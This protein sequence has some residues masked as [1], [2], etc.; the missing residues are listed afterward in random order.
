MRVSQPLP[1]KTK[2]MEKSGAA[3]RRRRDGDFVVGTMTFP[4]LSIFVLLPVADRSKAAR[5]RRCRCR[6]ARQRKGCRSN[7]GPA[8]H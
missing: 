1:K 7:V 8:E 3:S 5:W 2:T 6:V 4:L